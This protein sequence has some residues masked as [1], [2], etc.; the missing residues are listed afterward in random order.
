MSGA[1]F[2]ALYNFYLLHH[3]CVIDFIIYLEKKLTFKEM[4]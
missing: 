2:G 1:V 4:A 3:P